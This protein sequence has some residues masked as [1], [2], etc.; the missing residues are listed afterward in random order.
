M[1]RCKLLARRG[2]AHALA[3]RVAEALADH[4]LALKM[5]RNN[6]QLR[7]DTEELASCMKPLDGKSIYILL[8]SKSSYIQLL[9]IYQVV[10][11]KRS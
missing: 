7:K 2:R 10:I 11:N 1:A 6:E 9:Y 4:Q 3:G 5:D 8:G